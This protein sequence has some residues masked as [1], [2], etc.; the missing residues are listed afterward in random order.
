MALT[1]LLMEKV[2]ERLA[3]PKYPVAAEQTCVFVVSD[4]LTSYLDFQLHNFETPLICHC[5]FVTK[6]RHLI[7]KLLCK[8]Q[9]VNIPYQRLA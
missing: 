1:I 3:V 7:S 5:T 2:C 9:Q 4:L 6:F 8:N